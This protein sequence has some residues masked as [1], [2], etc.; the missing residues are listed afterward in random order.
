MKAHDAVVVGSGP[1]GLGAAVT[2][3]RAGLSVLVLEAAD[4]PGGG[5]RSGE[6]TLPGFTHDLCSAVHP[7]A[8]ASPLFRTL[9]LAELGLEW[10]ESPAAVAHPFDDGGCAL[11]FRDLARTA[12]GLGADGPR[13]RAVLG[14][15]ARRWEDVLGEV[16][17]PPVHVPRHPLLMARFGALALFPAV[18]YARLFFR[19]PR[20]RALFGGIAAH[21]NAPLEAAATAAI[22]LLL[23]LAGHARG[24]PI[25]K[26]GAQQITHALAAHLRSLG[27]EIRLGDR[28]L[29]AA[30]LP[31]S[32]LVL[33]DLGPRQL[34]QVLSGRLSRAE[35]EAFER[36]RHGPGVFKID[37]A[38]SAPIPW[39][40]PDAAKAATVHLGGTLEEI[41]ASEREPSRGKH[42]ERP[43]VLLS[44]PTLFDPARAPKG[45]HVAWAY[46][47]VPNGSRENRT[48]A[49]EDQIERFAPGFRD[50][51]LHRNVMDPA[52]LEARN[53]N[54]VGGDVNGGA[55][56]L[57]Q[58]L[59]RPRLRVDPYRLSAPG[60]FLCSSS[61]P[62]GPAVHGMCGFHAAQS[63]LRWLH[64]R[65]PGA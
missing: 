36:Y 13:Y 47:H 42:P 56:S 51:I 35:R 33:W 55:L 29:Q 54:L 7:L 45:K 9:P 20:T 23:N 14:A 49:I 5:A 2:L 63:A 30:H 64:G 24:W 62:P 4:A 46:C 26:G 44:Q 38:L 53:A 3:A 17:S 61:T 34:A 28:V 43:F 27:G 37:W 1:N 52:A 16:L 39:K 65:K 19:E 18:D 21:A 8:A 58:L 50:T 48:K 60:H 57:A 40:A 22:G 12:D 25:P 11:L 41:A 32:R 10:I 59:F 6:L 15:L 31:P